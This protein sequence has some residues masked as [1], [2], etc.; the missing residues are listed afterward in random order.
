VA[1]RGSL[2]RLDMGIHQLIVAPALEHSEKPEE[3]QNR[4]EKLY[5]GPYLEL[6]ARRVRSGWVCWGDE[7]PAAQAEAAHDGTQA[8]GKVDAAATVLA[9]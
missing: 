4:I 1:T 5:A 9:D 2:L 6:F 3:A 8:D 7:L